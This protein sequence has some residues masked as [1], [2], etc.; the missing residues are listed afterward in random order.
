MNVA[1]QGH[2]R[3]RGDASQHMTNYGHKRARM[4]SHRS[5]LKYA[6]AA[7]GHPFHPAVPAEGLLPRNSNALPKSKLGARRA[8][9][10]VHINEK[11]CRQ[12]QN[13]EAILH[14]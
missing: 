8:F 12:P 9:A 5:A 11:A 2:E 1:I 6:A 4:V 14:S 3:T 10:Y 13:L 7:V